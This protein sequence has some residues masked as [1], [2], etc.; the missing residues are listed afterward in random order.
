M[1]GVIHRHPDKATEL[2]VDEVGTASTHLR[3]GIARAMMDEM[4]AWG[5]ELG[6]TEA[7]LGT[8]LDNDRGQGLYRGYTPSEDEAIQ[9]LSVQ[10]LALRPVSH[11]MR[12]D[13][14]GPSPSNLASCGQNAVQFGLEREG[15]IDEDHAGAVTARP[16]SGVS[17]I[18]SAR[19]IL[20]MPVRFERG[21]EG[22]DLARLLERIPQRIDAAGPFAMRLDQ[23]RRPGARTRRLLE[24]RI[25]QH[26]AALFL[27]RQMGAERQPAVE[28]R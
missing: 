9:Y 5:R 8:E 16:S 13:R 1:R 2:Y 11:S 19:S 21:D 12:G 25:D 10:A 7:W 24:G 4:F 22:V 27:G 14:H 17:I 20:G 26:Q 6:C 15:R 18:S 23:A 3:Q 28:L